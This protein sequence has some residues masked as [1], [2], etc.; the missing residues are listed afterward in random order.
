MIS[1]GR[2]APRGNKKPTEKSTQRS[3]GALEEARSLS[4]TPHDDPAMGEMPL[5]STDEDLVRMYL[6]DMAEH[7]LLTREQEIQYGR[8]RAQANAK[9]E[10]ILLQ[11]D[12]IARRCLSL[13]RAVSQGLKRL[14]HVLDVSNQDRQ[15]K[16]K[17]R[18]MLNLHDKTITGVLERNRGYLNE[19]LSRKGDPQLKEA[20]R[21]R[22]ASGR[23][24]QSTLLSEV[25]IKFPRLAEFKEQ[26]R[27]FALETSLLQVRLK[28][29]LLGAE[30]S[31]G[32]PSKRAAPKSQKKSEPELQK[33]RDES[34]KITA[35]I[36]KCKG[37]SSDYGI[38]LRLPEEIRALQYVLQRSETQQELIPHQNAIGQ[39]IRSI[40][41]RDTELKT[42]LAFLDQGDRA[43]QAYETPDA[44]EQ[45]RCSYTE[46]AKELG[47]KAAL[48]DIDLASTAT[49]EEVFAM[50]W[51]LRQRILV[52]GESPQ[53][54][55]K[56]LSR[57]DGFLSQATAATEALAKGNLRLVVA[58]AK[59]Y[60]NR[61][62]DFL[63]LI[64]E[65][66]A[67]LL[68]AANKFDYSRRFKFSTYATH[69]LR[70]RLL[71]VVSDRSGTI[72]VPPHAVYQARE[73]EALAG[74]LEQENGRSLSEEERLV[75][76][77]QADSEKRNG[78]NAGSKAASRIGSGKSRDKQLYKN[79]R[80]LESLTHA[81]ATILSLDQP[82]EPHGEH[83]FGNY[84]PSNRDDTGQHQVD[85]AD[86]W[87]LLSAEMGNLK[88]REREIL[89][90][91]Y[92]LAGG[93]DGM[94]LDEVGRTLKIT[95]ERVRQIQ[96]K[97]LRKLQDRLGKKA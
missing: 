44:Y 34:K 70:Q 63:D 84:I 50:K 69:W 43:K 65:G 33:L 51:A 45:A 26:L 2:G 54:A 49:R 10:T 37:G 94:T 7:P 83:S 75:A 4:E 82:S 95:R 88:S 12:F 16:A 39:R 58:E 13:M 31:A 90:L 23:R 38:P 96:T 74:T 47:K 61:G 6:Q 79:A 57:C 24:H 28:L 59:R 1:Q 77:D 25:K 22:H 67:G 20:M 64:Q 35:Q 81:T 46:T 27:L 91:R 93:S 56:R 73:F 92:G 87:K 11:S 52:M 62:V 32:E 30:Q 48:F 97:A 9:A 8:T 5:P 55:L 15:E 72:K 18:A 76:F 71:R 80:H 19:R 17:A 21:T 60:R 66:N 78:G 29:A 89:S 53:A 41:Q 68:V 14:D 36:K 42:A 40:I 3:D 86:L 85:N